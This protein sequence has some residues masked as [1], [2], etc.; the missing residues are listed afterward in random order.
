MASFTRL[1][2]TVARE[3]VRKRRRTSER[4][5]GKIVEG[6]VMKE[7]WSAGVVL[8]LPSLQ[9]ERI[10]HCVLIDFNG[11]FSIVLGNETLTNSRGLN[12]K[13]TY[14]P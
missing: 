5:E 14:R 2:V 13:M 6:S 11:P 12:Y 7:S 1:E 8:A 9:Q 3:W 4:E 10:R